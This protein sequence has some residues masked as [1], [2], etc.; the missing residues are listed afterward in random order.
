M[1]NAPPLRIWLYSVLLATGVIALLILARNVPGARYDSTITG[2]TQTFLSNPSLNGKL[3]VLGFG[4]SLLWAATSSTNNEQPVQL[5]NVAWMRMTKGGTGMGYLQP[6]LDIVN[7][8]PPDVL[9]FEENMLLPDE[10]NL[11]M[12]PLR[13]D[14]WHLTKQT[15]SVLTAGRFASPQPSYWENND[16][17]RPYPCIA[18]MLK[19]T[20]AQIRLQIEELQKVYL[21]A[22]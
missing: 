6:A 10:G 16:Q 1:A 22:D 18:D 20:E 9:V 21:Q 13:E 3:R 14:L 5:H 4:S 15:V 11:V 19:L 2:R 17:E 8:N 12:D 7:H